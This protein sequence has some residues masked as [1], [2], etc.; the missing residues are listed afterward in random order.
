[1]CH[2][3][4]AIHRPHNN[5]EI[6]AEAYFML[7]GIQKDKVDSAW[8]KFKYSANDSSKFLKNFN[9][10]EIEKVPKTTIDLL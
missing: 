9:D 7:F 4:K 5:W 10:F 3:L 1:M 2:E 6:V 8:N